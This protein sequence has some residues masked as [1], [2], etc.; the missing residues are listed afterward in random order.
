MKLSSLLHPRYIKVKDP[1]PD[2]ETLIRNLVRDFARDKGWEE[3]EI[4]RLVLEREK[5]GPTV[6]RGISIPHARIEGFQDVFIAISIPEKPIKVKEEEV[7]IFFLI[8]TSKTASRLYLN[9]L[10]AIAR[11]A[12]NPAV[13]EKILGANRPEDVVRLIEEADIR[14]KEE[15]TVREIMEEDFP[16][17]FPDTSLKDIIDLFLEKDIHYLPVVEGDKLVGEITL[18]DILHMGIPHYVLSIANVRFLKTLEPLETLLEKEEVL[19][20]KEIMQEVKDWLNPGDYLVVAAVK[21]LKKKREVL[22]VLEEG[23]L[24][25]ILSILQFLKRI[26]RI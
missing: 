9:T 1:S 5:Q 3:E 21:M 15:L 17:V 11:L 19:T 6:E 13:M 8:L 20:A 4:T 14:V 22:P 24:V 16:R 2:N 25:G 18:L 7:R 23:K 10:S 12:N 26:L